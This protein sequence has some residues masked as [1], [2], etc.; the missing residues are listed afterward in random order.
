MKGSL[1][2]PGMRPSTT[3]PPP[4]ICRTSF[5]WDSWRMASVPRSPVAVERVTMRPVATLI[6]SAGTWLTR[7]SPMLSS[8]YLLIDSAGPRPCCTIPMTN[9]PM[10]LII[11]MTMPATASP[12]TNFD[13]PS[14]AP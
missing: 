8:A 7:P 5:C 3:M 4:A 11:T 13:E 6:S 9:P 10:R 2:M 1:G 14:I 12:L